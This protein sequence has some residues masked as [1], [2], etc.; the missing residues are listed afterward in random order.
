M[1]SL[2][3]LQREIGQWQAETFPASTLSSTIKHLQKEVGELDRD[4][5][6]EEAAD[7]VILLIEVANHM[8]ICLQTEVEIKDAINRLRQWGEPDEHG[9]VEHIS[10][11]G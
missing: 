7:C 10:Q 11:G 6:P 2:S 3:D 4:R 8:G 5:S 1:K 9:V